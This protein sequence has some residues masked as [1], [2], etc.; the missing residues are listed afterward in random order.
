MGCGARV[1]KLKAETFLKEKA[2]EGPPSKD[3]TSGGEPR[4]TFILG[5]INPVEF[6][7]HWEND[8]P[9]DGTATPTPATHVLWTP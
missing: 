3:N 7:G 4:S 2:D 8:H 9:K 5:G 6:S 1:D